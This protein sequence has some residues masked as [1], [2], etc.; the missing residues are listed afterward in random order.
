LDEN[1]D[2]HQT[3]CDPG[4]LATKP[5]DNRVEADKPFQQKNHSFKLAWF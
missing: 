1:N 2:H 3:D 5:E 4:K